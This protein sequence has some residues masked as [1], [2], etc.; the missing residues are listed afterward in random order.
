MNTMLLLKIRRGSW[1]SVRLMSMLFIQCRFFGLKRNLIV[2]LKGTKPIL[3]VMAGLN[4]LVWT[5]KSLSASGEAHNYLDCSQHIHVQIM[6]HSSVG[7]QK[8]ILVGSTSRNRL[9]ASAYGIQRSRSSRL[10]VFLL[11]KTLYGLQLAPR[12][13]YQRFADF[14]STI[15]FS[16]SASDH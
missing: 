13:W 9:Y 7:C 16:N 15:G 2:P 14:V 4:R 12:A 11:K 5:I 6:V 3:L 8:C 1:C 10:C